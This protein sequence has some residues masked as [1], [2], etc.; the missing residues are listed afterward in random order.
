MNNEYEVG[1]VGLGTMGRNLML[2]IADH[3]YDV[4]GLVRDESKVKSLPANGKT[5]A[6]IK[7]TQDKKVFLDSLRKP[8]AILLLVPAG[9]AIDEVINDLSPQLQVGDLV[10]DAGNSHFTD[11][12]RREKALAEKGFH[13]FGMGVSGG[14]AGA[15]NGP[16]IMP[17]GNKEAYERI[18]PVL[19]AIA[20]KVNGDP[21][22]TYLGPRSTGHY[23]KMV[24]N[25]IEYGLMQL[26]AE[27]YHLMKAAL[28]LSDDECHDVYK[29]WNGSELSSYLLEITAQIFLKK[30]DKSDGR[31]I[32]AVRDV[33]KQKGTGKWVCQDAM[34]LQVPLPT[35]DA[36]VGLRDLSILET[37]R[38]TAH[39][40]FDALSANLP[41]ERTPFL[42]RLRNA[43]YLSSIITFAQGMALLQKASATY[44]YE[45]NLE[46]VARIWRGGCIIRADLLETIMAAYQTTPHLTN[47]LFDPKLEVKVGKYQADLRA[48]VQAA[49]GLGFPVPALMASLAYYD[50]FRSSWLP[51]NLIQA[52]RDYFGAHTY[53]RNDQSGTFHSNWESQ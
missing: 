45:L 15:R 48:V 27:T 46:V 25:G 17:G 21:C 22:A 9:A 37:D 42:S 20:A 26:I 36:A 41:I 53:E 14:E 32:D 5:G 28:K 7:A 35:I 40:L 6:N 34:E 33:A 50:S 29:Q 4:I 38:K 43:Y 23:V 51:S 24:H 30:D 18:R 12:N 49:A 16:S 10:I 44:G 3:G 52:Q 2:N 13:F 8:R 39:H 47:L 11:T 31:L 1:I 19:E